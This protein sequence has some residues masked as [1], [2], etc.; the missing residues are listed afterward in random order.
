[1]TEPVKNYVV[2]VGLLVLLSGCLQGVPGISGQTYWDLE[3]A[4]EVAQEGQMNEFNG[5]VGLGGNFG[6]VTVESVR[7]EFVDS[8]NE[9][10]RV[11]TIGTL[12]ASRPVVPFTVKLNRPPQYVL[13]TY[14]SVD[15]PD[16]MDY[17]ISRGLVQTASG[18]YEAI[19][20]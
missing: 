4:G 19:S 7:L 20:S 12:N 9:T 5:E 13:L 18:E 11:L 10:M 3:I 2:G 1:M 6:P 15:S 16:N 14:D 17:S 8:N